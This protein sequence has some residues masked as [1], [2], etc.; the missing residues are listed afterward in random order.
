MPYVKLSPEE[1]QAAR[2]QALAK[3]I[4]TRRAMMLTRKPKASIRIDRDVIERIT[5]LAISES[6]DRSEILT[7][8]MDAYEAAKKE[9]EP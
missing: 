1:R 6:L 9:V 5:D 4:A 3:S 2:E 7:R 8:C